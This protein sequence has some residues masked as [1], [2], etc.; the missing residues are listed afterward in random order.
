MTIP[1]FIEELQ[2]KR[3]VSTGKPRDYEVLYMGGVEPMLTVRRPF[4]Y[5]LPQSAASVIEV[6]Q[7]HGV[8]VEELREDVELDVEVY[9]ID[10]VKRAADFQKHQPITLQATPRADSRR[11][12]AGTILIRTKQPL[13]N[14]AA[15]LL[16][17][18]SA[19][20]LATWNFFDADLAPGR[21]FPVLRLPAATPIHSGPV[22]PLK[23]ERTFKKPITFELINSGERPNFTGSPSSG[24]TWLD[25]GEHYL[26]QREG[27]LYKVHARSGRAQPFLDTDKLA[28]GLAGI[29]SIGPEAAKSLAQSAGL[30]MNPERTAAFHRVW[31]RKE[32]WLKARGLGIAIPLDS[33]EVS[34]AA[35]DAR[36]LA[37]RPDPAAAAR[38]SLRDIDPGPGF[39]GCV[40]AEG[41]I[42]ELRVR[43]LAGA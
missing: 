30:K 32:A 10:D 24:H 13:G 38:W 5:L 39:A 14:L 3:R 8:R 2:G 36:L 35:G 28:A 4:G 37:T 9:R 1:G 17:P 12:Q 29:P 31:T 23:E 40:A 11:I 26:Q 25:D 18:Q 15:Y 27:R 19:D 42:R 34:H 33:F 20:G 16:E 7:R 43:S 22:R 6:L 41:P 21:D